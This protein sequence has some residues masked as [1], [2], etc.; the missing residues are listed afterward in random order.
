ML[1]YYVDHV[2][3]GKEKFV[4]KKPSGKW[5]FVHSNDQL[6][7]MKETGKWDDC[8]VQLHSSEASGWGSLFSAKSENNTEWVW[9]KVKGEWK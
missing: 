8:V 1:G 5:F 6:D 4:V 9:T 2:L 3:Q 7:K